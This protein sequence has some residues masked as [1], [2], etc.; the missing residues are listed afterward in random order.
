[1]VVNCLLL[2]HMPPFL[3]C[4][5]P[6]VAVTT[7]NLLY[8][9]LFLASRVESSLA[10]FQR[11]S[12]WVLVRF[13][14]TTVMGFFDCSMLSSS[15]IN[16]GGGRHTARSNFETSGSSISIT[17]LS[18]NG[19]MMVF[20]SHTI[21]AHSSTICLCAAWNQCLDFTSGVKSLKSSTVAFDTT[22]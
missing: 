14:N 13:E 17:F 5:P 4:A 19:R 2:C 6:D 16:D 10:L 11:F 18:K 7:L 1:M 22:S 15:P 20:V 3:A 12:I 21:F 8:L 9:R